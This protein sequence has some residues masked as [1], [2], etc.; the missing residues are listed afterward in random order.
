LKTLE[1]RIAAI[2]NR[3]QR[4]ELDKKWET[5]W[6]RRLS[7]ATLTY[8]VVVGYLFVIGNDRPFINAIVP[9]VG[10]ILSTLVMKQIRRLWQ[11]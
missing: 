1:E 9:P 8:L 7:I 5:S 4:V 10:F 3:N 2:E 6:I 11:K